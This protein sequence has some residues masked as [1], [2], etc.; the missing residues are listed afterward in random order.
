MWRVWARCRRFW[1]LLSNDAGATSDVSEE[2]SSHLQLHMDDNLRAGMAEKEARRHALVR[3]GGAR[4]IREQHDD[5]RRIR[6]VEEILQD[7]RHAL[8]VMRANPGFTGAA[9]TTL[10]LAVGANTAVFSVVNAILLKPLPF[11]EPERIVVFLN[12]SPAI[13]TAGA[14]PARFNFWKEQANALQDIAGFRFEA[15]SLTGGLEPEQVTLGRVSQRFFELF[16]VTPMHGRSFTDDEDRPG[17]AQVAVLGQRLWQRRFAGDPAV[18]GTNVVLGGSA[19]QIIGVA[20]STFDGIDPSGFVS[21]GYKPHAFPDIWVPLQLDSL[22]STHGFTLNAAARLKPGVTLA[23]ARAQ[24]DVV[25]EAFRLRYPNILPADGGFGLETL[26]REI[27]G[28]TRQA[29]WVLQGTALLVL[30]IACANVGNLLLVRATARSREWR[31]RLAIGA[32]R[33]RLIRQ[34]VTE[35]LVLSMIGGALG[36][37]LGTTAVRVMLA[38]VTTGVQVLGATT[39]PLVG[40]AGS[41]VTLDWRVLLCACAVTTLTGLTFCVLPVLAVG[42]SKLTAALKGSGLQLGMSRGPFRGAQSALVVI[43]V[44]LALALV[45]G[46]GLLAKT[47]TG[48]QRIE[49]GF[50]TS[51]VV[52]LSMSFTGPSVINTAVVDRVAREGERR[53][54]AVPGIAAAGATVGLPLHPHAIVPFQIMGRPRRGPFHGGAAWFSVS[55]GL[56]KAMELPLIRGRMLSDGD[57]ALGAR[58]AL[59]NRTMADRYWPKED[60]LGGQLVVGGPGLAP[61]QPMQVVGIVGD[62]RD[63]TLKQAPTPTIYVPVGQV[64]D[65]MTTM[66]LTVLPVSWVIRTDAASMP[67]VPAIRRELQQASGLPVG[68]VVSMEDAIAHSTA[69]AQINM[70]LSA[71]FAG[72]AVLLAVVGV[73]GVMAFAVARRTSEIGIRLALGATAGRV[74]ALLLGQG[75]TLVSI[76]LGAGMLCAYGLGSVMASLLFEV[77]PH[78]PVILATV[79]AGLAVVALIAAWIPARRA[80]MVQPVVAL[81]SE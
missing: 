52:T 40:N 47:L 20:G 62:I 22:D 6:L 30:L 35:S 76:G 17:G 59:I 43:Q 36:L 21:S 23:A 74:R 44:A 25:A 61:A 51:R 60:P 79:P 77:T 41:A 24:M 49:P 73:Y 48:L 53:L 46:A 14:S 65:Q 3:L 19:Y 28:S 57:S 31:I 16:D 45:V 4:A 9:V 12:T 33:G 13:T 66:N 72:I 69:G 32:A 81:R 71:S 80:A 34:V 50:T 37:V 64:P 58:V 7:L 5:G 63:Y 18:I 67:L 1:D 56:S 11:P 42:R 70:L 15:V 26:Q 2:L 10:A 54:H 55:P 38:G 75:I 39:L 29:L 78:D 8:R 68:P 27:V